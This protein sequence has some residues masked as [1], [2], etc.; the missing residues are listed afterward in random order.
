MNQ[1][2]QIEHGYS[3]SDIGTPCGKT[4]MAE[5]ADCGSSIC[6]NCRTEC[7][8]ESFC[9]QCYDYHVA[10]SCVRKPVQNERHYPTFGS[11]DKTG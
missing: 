11:T 4:A 1:F 10:H 8:G 3:D 5:C 9:A 2:C 7:C 6:Y